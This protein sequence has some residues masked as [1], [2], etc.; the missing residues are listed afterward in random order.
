MPC[1]GFLCVTGTY[2]KGDPRPEG[3]LDWH[4]WARVQ[5]RAGLRQRQC[6]MCSKWKYPQ[7][8]SSIEHTHKVVEAKTG[9]T[10][11]LTDPVCLACVEANRYGRHTDEP[12]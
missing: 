11:V 1:V 10:L 6:C 2:K 7:E 3:Y 5:H 12:V 4:E 9:R 8:L